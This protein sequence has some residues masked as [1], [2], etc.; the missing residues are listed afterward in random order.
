MVEFGTS[1]AYMGWVRV[2]VLGY[3]FGVRGK[4]VKSRDCALASDLV[5]AADA[6]MEDDRKVK[7]CVQTTNRHD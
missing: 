5:K 1:S 2:R 6:S 4:K 3:G 7:V